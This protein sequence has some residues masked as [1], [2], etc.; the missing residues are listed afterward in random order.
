MVASPWLLWLSL[1][2]LMLARACNPYY[3]SPCALLAVLIN[4]R[5][6]A[7]QASRGDECPGLFCMLAKKSPRIIDVSKS[8]DSAYAALKS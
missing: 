6:E 8:D 3:W 5:D 2:E 7:W 1:L 4:D